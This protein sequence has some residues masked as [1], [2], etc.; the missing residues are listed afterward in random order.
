MADYTVTT[1]FSAK[2][3][4]ATGDSN[5]LVAGAPV[6][7]ELANIATAIATKYDSNDLASQAQA[8]AETSNA[9]I[10]TPLRVAN[11]SDANGGM[12]GDIHALADPNAD[13][14]LGW[15]DSAGAVIGYALGTGIQTDVTGIQIEL[16]HLGIEDLTDPG[17]DRLMYWDDSATAMNWLTVDN[18]ITIDADDTMGLTDV[19]AG[20]AQPVVVTSGT[21]TF[22]LSS[23]TEIA[24]SGLA[25]SADGI[26]ISDAGTIKV[27][28]LDQ[29]GAPVQTGQGTQTLAL[30]DMNTVMEFTATATLT[31]PTN[32][33]VAL[34]VG[35]GILLQM[36]HATQVLTITAASGVTLSSI[37]HPAGVD[38][39]SDTVV[40]GG[41]AV[42]YKKATD[43][44][45]L[46][47]DIT[48]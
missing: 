14:L 29:A 2:D 6:D 48:T 21:Y 3:A 40:A 26:V 12:I 15:D 34:E 46:S 32:A 25:Q 1:D 10:M 39:A 8:E 13:S 45:C 41:S 42:L 9:V 19:S 44:W 38:N 5:K 36:S 22:D 17:A 30:T 7:T 27:M 20:A 35:A 24:A 28:P 23:I 18:G 37:F 11:W 47:G 43:A 33:S 16:G 31:I 4:L